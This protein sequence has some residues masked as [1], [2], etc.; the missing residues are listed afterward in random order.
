MVDRF[1]AAVAA[2]DYVAN[3][4]SMAERF[5]GQFGEEDGKLLIGWHILYIHDHRVKVTHGWIALDHR[6]QRGRIREKRLDARWRQREL[7]NQRWVR[8]GQYLDGRG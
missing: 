8:R 6:H 3:I 2:C 7:H 4:F 5:G 1:G